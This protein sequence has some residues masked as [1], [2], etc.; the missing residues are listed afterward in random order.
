MVLVTCEGCD[1]H[2]I[3]ADN[4]NWFSD[5]NGLKNI[6]QIL[7]AKCETVTHKQMQYLVQAPGME[8]HEDS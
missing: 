7:E 5:L 4:L 2:H 6:E 8:H 1:N 3:I